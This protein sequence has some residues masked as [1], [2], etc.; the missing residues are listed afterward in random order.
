MTVRMHPSDNELHPHRF[1][2]GPTHVTQTRFDQNNATENTYCKGSFGVVKLKL[3]EEP[4]DFNPTA[5]GEYWIN[6]REI[7]HTEN[8]IH[9]NRKDLAPFLG[10]CAEHEIERV[11]DLTAWTIE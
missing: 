10:W 5:A 8:T 7:D 1:W 3:P 11:G 6:K 2:P 4:G 9:S